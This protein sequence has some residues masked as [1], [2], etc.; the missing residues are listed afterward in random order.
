MALEPHPEMH[1][2]EADLGAREPV[3]REGDVKEIADLVRR[4]N[5]GAEIFTTNDVDCVASSSNAR[6]ASANPR[7]PR[8]PLCHDHRNRESRRQQ[9]PQVQD[10]ATPFRPRRNS[11]AAWPWKIRKE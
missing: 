6:C 4:L 8:S 7:E 3:V 1:S 11:R 9:K 5:L 10:S 2:L